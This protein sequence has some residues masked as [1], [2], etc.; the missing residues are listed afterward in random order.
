MA[1]PTVTSNDLLGDKNQDMSLEEVLKLIEAKE[2]GKRSTGHL[3]Q[4]RE[5]MLP[6][7]STVV[8]SRT[9]LKAATWNKTDPTRVRKNE[10]PAYSTICGHWVEANHLE[11]ICHSK[12]KPNIQHHDPS[13]SAAQIWSWCTK[14]WT[15]RKVMGR[16]GIFIL[17][18]FFF[19]PLFVQEFFFWMESSALNFYFFGN[20][21]IISY[22]S[23]S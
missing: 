2:A 22:T 3:L 4:H 20:M 23:L 17:L 19:C 9:T 12:G 1:L 16:V 5:L 6:A 15:I 21:H 8:L 10:C 14:G 11:A 7:A 18:E 13:S